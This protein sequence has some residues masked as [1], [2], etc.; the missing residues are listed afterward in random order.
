MRMKHRVFLR[1]DVLGRRGKGDVRQRAI[2]IDNEIFDLIVFN[3]L[4]E[5]KLPRIVFAARRAVLGDLG[6]WL[7]FYSADERAGR[8]A[9]SDGEGENKC[10]QNFHQ[11]AKPTS[12]A[13][14]WTSSESP[15]V[16]KC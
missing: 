10:G 4:H 3:R 16:T 13:R 11:K 8:R 1:D 15:L 2:E 12:A 6:L 7:G 5:L 14:K 9:G